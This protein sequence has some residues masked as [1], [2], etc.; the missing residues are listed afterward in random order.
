MA[1][2]RTQGGRAAMQEDEVLCHG[3]CVGYDG[4]DG[5]SS[6]RR[7]HALLHRQSGDE[8]GSQ[9]IFREC[10]RPRGVVTRCDRK[11]A[12]AWDFGLWK[13]AWPTTE[14]S[15]APTRRAVGWKHTLVS[16]R[17]QGSRSAPELEGDG[18]V[19]VHG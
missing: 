19:W 14:P 11:L 15:V 8:G 12:N 4:G 17:V 13:G 10:S 7:S 2:S 1:F 16:H 9:G 18:V 6:R 5:G 3:S